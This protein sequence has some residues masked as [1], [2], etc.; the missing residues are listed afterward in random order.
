L[1]SSYELECTKKFADRLTIDYAILT[2]IT[3]TVFF[4][5]YKFL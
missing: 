3:H 5:A 1:P 4:I 2:V